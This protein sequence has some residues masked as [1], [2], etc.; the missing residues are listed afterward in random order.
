MS[1]FKVLLIDDEEELVD[2]LVERLGYRDID[3]QYA[4]DGH[5]AIKKMRE[6]GFDVVVLD[7]KLP[8]MSGHEVLRRLK[9]SYPDVPVLLI[10]G[11]G[12]PAGEIEPLP[13]GAFDYLIKPVQLD[14]LIDKMREAV[15][16]RE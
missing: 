7:V 3:A 4:L 1:E 11:H 15:K 5:S 14:V 13:D 16:S 9:Q 6:G 12:T 2:A 8:G 10:T